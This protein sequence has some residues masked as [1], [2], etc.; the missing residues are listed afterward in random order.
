MRAA[1][2]SPT[3]TIEQMLDEPSRL[4]IYAMPSFRPEKRLERS[5]PQVVVEIN[6]V[7]LAALDRVIGKA[8]E[9]ISTTLDSVA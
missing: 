5:E 7:R 8:G 9:I 1:F 3:G 4:W 2:G 6:G